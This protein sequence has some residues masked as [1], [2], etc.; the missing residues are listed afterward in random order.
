M[1]LEGSKHHSARQANYTG[2]QTINVRGLSIALPA[3]GD[4]SVIGGIADPGGE[5]VRVCYAQGNSAIFFNLSGVETDR[6]VNS[7]SAEA[8][9]NEIA[10]SV[11]VGGS[12]APAPSVCSLARSD[13]QY[14]GSQELYF[15]NFAFVLSD[16]RYIVA[17]ISEGHGPRVEICYVRDNSTLTLDPVSGTEISRD[18]RSADAG[19]AFD[20]IVRSA[21]TTGRC[22]AD[23]GTAGTMPTGQSGIKP[24]DTGDAGLASGDGS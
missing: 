15:G 17:Q 1:W 19:A 3:G 16:G 12:A 5:F 8:V 4:Y 14:E 24:P 23:C 9:L 11:R 13:L 21:R 10:A 7:P 22:L 18:A 20:R 2:G 6:I